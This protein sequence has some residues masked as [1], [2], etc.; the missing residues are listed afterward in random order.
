MP[1]TPSTSSSCSFTALPGSTGR[2]ANNAFR[3]I[4]LRFYNLRLV[5]V[6][7]APSTSS[8]CVSS[9]FGLRLCRHCVYLHRIYILPCALSARYITSVRSHLRYQYI[10]T[11]N[12]TVLLPN[13][14][15]TITTTERS[16]ST[17][18]PNNIGRHLCGVGG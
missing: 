5:V 14:I 1:I 10:Y 16:T 7:T 3:Y 17:P 18:H 12:R 9:F 2:R 15:S 13:G 11:V 4:V 6:P 8:F